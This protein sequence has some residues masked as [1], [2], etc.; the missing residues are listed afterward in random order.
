MKVMKN[1]AFVVIFLFLSVCL[2][3]A[4]VFLG[5]V[6]LLI[7]SRLPERVKALEE[8]VNGIDVLDHGQY[9]VVDKRY[10]IGPEEWE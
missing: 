8:G 7:S 9:I 1:G 5:E 4:V 2:L 10:L 3:L 6:S